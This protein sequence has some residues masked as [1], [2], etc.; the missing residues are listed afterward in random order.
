MELLNQQRERLK[1][2]AQEAWIEFLK[3]F[4]TKY[5]Q[6][7]C[8]IRHLATLDCLLSL[9]AVAEH[10]G[11]VRPVFGMCALISRNMTLL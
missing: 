2:V 4:A 3:S 10:A 6:F 9:T 11:Y 7:R 8:A 1:I 5:D